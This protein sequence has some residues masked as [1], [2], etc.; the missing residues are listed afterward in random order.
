MFRDVFYS[1][2]RRAVGRP[3]GREIFVN[4][5]NTYYYYYYR[6]RLYANDS[7]TACGVPTCVFRI[8]GMEKNSR[9]KNIRTDII[10]RVVRRRVFNHPTDLRR[11]VTTRRWRRR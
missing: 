11:T 6:R 7:R 8:G 10:A 5:C 4:I 3:C 2:C 1:V 9:K